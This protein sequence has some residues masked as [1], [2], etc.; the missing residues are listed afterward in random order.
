MI[1]DL[2]ETYGILDYRALPINLIGTLVS[3]LRDDSRVKMALA[4]A[5]VPME[6]LLLAAIADRLSALVWFNTKDGIKGRNKPKSLMEALQFPVEK[7]D[8]TT[9]EA[10]EDFEEEWRRLCG[11]VQQWQEQN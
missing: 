11:E 9:F 4:G 6:Q 2:A 5:K 3:G 1:C 10:G 8:Y 7:D